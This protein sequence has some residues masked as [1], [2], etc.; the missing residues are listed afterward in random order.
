MERVL[1]LPF[2][3][4]FIFSPLLLA[5]VQVDV[6]DITSDAIEGI[7]PGS[8]IM[9]VEPLYPVAEARRGAEGWVKLSFVILQ[10]GSVV[11]PVVVDSSGNRGFERE[12]KKALK[13]WK[14][15]PA[16]ED[17][18]PIV[19]CANTVQL[20]FRIDGV[21]KGASKNFKKVYQEAKDALQ[22]KNLPVAGEIILAMEESRNWN[23]YEDAWRWSLEAELAELEKDDIKLLNAINRAAS[24]GYKSYLGLPLYFELMYKK[25]AIEFETKKYADAMETFDRIS[26]TKDSE[27][28]ISL[29]AKYV[30]FIRAS[31]ASSQTI[32]VQ[33]QIFEQGSWLHRLSRNRFS[34]AKLEG[35][36]NNL[37][38]RCEYRWEKFN[39]AVE[40]L[41][42]SHEWNVPASWGK[43]SVL[44]EGSAHT[45][46]N[47]QELAWGT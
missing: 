2:L 47:V 1:K 7:T 32:E 37:E 20:N 3:F 5:Q 42:G 46:F 29:L 16:M 13:K 4:L 15:S 19:H 45:R 17:G 34:L 12:A 28:V 26:Q 9:R 22:N 43:C 14:Y 40:W 39:L 24:E 6:S 8:A 31:L 23:S 30:Y 33:G 25:F 41:D 44:V 18:K 36:I 35:E 21:S 11:E 10:D 27:E 38:L